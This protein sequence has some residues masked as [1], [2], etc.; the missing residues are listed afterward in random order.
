[1]ATLNKHGTVVCVNCNDPVK[2]V[3]IYKDPNHQGLT[4]STV[5]ICLNC[6]YMSTWSA[7]KPQ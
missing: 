7:V 1:M 3:H 5:T 4:G 2:S 6:N